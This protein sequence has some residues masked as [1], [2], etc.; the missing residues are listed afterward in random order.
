MSCA[1]L[2]FIAEKLLVESGRKSNKNSFNIFEISKESAC[3][4]LN[5]AMPYN[6]TEATGPTDRKVIETRAAVSIANYCI[7]TCASKEP[8][9]KWRSKSSVSFEFFCSQL[10]LNWGWLFL[11]QKCGMR[12]CL[13]S[14]FLRKH[15]C[16]LWSVSSI[17]N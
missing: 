3:N 13:S 8:S 6:S 10:R 2:C 11:S 4:G 15:I 17:R 5:R 14:S 16:A 9:F 1:D 7:L 12:W